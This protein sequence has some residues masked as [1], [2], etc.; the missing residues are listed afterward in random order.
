MIVATSDLMSLLPAGSVSFY[1]ETGQELSGIGSGAI[2][3]ARLRPSRWVADV[4]ASNM[5]LWTY[6]Q[7]LAL[8]DV[9]DGS[10]STFLMY[11][12]A[13]QYP[14]SDPTGS[15][16]GASTVQIQSVGADYKSLALKGLPANYV[17]S[18]GD[19]IQVTWF[20]P[21]RIALHRVIP[22]SVTADGSGIT[23]EFEVRPHIIDGMAANDACS[24]KQPAAEMLMVPGSLSVNAQPFSGSISFKA[25]Q[26]L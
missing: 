14:T 2:I 4:N 22:S 10:L 18:R 15:I 25:V 5:D 17:L 7:C 11:D 12:H 8:I 21:A 20:S 1:L 19:L 24:I 16:V 26:M 13:N 9:L 6:K 3:A 23:A